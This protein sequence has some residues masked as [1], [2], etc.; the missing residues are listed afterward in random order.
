VVAAPA[1]GAG[2][3]CEGI[4]TVMTFEGSGGAGASAE[5]VGRPKDVLDAETVI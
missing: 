3:N 4:V 2:A 1:V 5:D